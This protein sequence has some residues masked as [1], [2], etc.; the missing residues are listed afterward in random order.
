MKLLIA[1]TVAV[2][3][4]CAPAAVEAGPCTECVLAAT[5]CGIIC[6]CD[7]PACE[8]CPECGACL[9]DH[10]ES[11]EACCECLDL[12]NSADVANG[13]PAF[14]RIQAKISDIIGAKAAKAA[15]STTPA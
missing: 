2:L 1:L 14:M 5:E 6:S 4:A 10:G 13:A 11:F 9:A 15:N 8:C 7:W 12:C 3:S